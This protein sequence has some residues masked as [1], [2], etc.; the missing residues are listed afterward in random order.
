MSCESRLGAPGTAGHGTRY[1]VSGTTA[2]LMAR[3][4][5]PPGVA[6]QLFKSA[7]RWEVKLHLL[8]GIT[9]LGWG[10]ILAHHWRAIDWRVY[11]HRYVYPINTTN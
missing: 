9:L 5:A 1:F 2:A 4:A 6:D 8:S 10:K 3:A 11:F 7:F